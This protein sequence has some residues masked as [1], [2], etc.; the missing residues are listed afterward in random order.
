MRQTDHPHF[1]GDIQIIHDL[2][3]TYGTFTSYGKCMECS[4][5][6]VDVQVAR[7]PQKMVRTPKTDKA[8]TTTS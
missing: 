2:Q 7:S 5:F 4:Q 1:A 3:L 8:Q 6:M